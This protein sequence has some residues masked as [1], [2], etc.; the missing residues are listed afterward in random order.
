MPLT[1]FVSLALAAPLDAK[2]VQD[3]PDALTRYAVGVAD[4]LQGFAAGVHGRDPG[5]APVVSR[6]VRVHADI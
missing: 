6:K 5:L 2:A 3:L 1:R 4:L